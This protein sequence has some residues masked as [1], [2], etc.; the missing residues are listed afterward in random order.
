MKTTLLDLI[1]VSVIQT[2]LSR[3]MDTGGD[4]AEIYLQKAAPK[5]SRLRRRRS[6][7]L[8]M[9]CRVVSASESSKEPKSVM[10]IPMTYLRPRCTRLLKSQEQLRSPGTTTR[11]FKVAGQPT[12]DRYPIH[13]DPG[14]V[15]LQKN[16]DAPTGRP[17]C[18]LLR[19]AHFTS[20]GFFRRCYKRSPYRQLRGSLG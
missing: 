17:R 3:A 18:P 7:R 12:P 19:H 9:G 20:H 11:S 15:D 5:V 13:A 1:P 6:K 14:A 2:L 8:A 10:P 16:R 4:F